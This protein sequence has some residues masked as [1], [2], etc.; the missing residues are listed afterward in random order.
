LLLS[1]KYPHNEYF[2]TLTFSFCLTS[3]CLQYEILMK[4]L[5]LF[6]KEASIYDI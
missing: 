6:W 2:C 5:I 1:V 3:L 4:F